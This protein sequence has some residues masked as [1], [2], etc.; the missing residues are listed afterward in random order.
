MMLQKGKTI[1]FDTE[2]AAAQYEQYQKFIQ[3]GEDLNEQFSLMNANIT[4]ATDAIQGFAQAQLGA[5]KFENIEKLST[6]LD[7]YSAQRSRL[8]GVTKGDADVI[9][10]SLAASYGSLA[11]YGVSFGQIVKAQNN[12]I[13]EFNSY[14]CECTRCHNFVPLSEVCCSKNVNNN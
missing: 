2:A 8:L 14:E 3:S 10:E 13:T 1:T 7:K 4:S 11:Q 5:F 12:F 6:E 9:K